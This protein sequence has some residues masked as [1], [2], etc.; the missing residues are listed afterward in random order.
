[1]A[2]LPHSSRLQATGKGANRHLLLWTPQPLASPHSTLGHPWEEGWESRTTVIITAN[3]HWT[4]LGWALSPLHA[5]IPILRAVPLWHVYYLPSRF[6]TEEAEVQTDWVTSPGSESKIRAL[7]HHAPLLEGETEKLEILVPKIR[8]KKDAGYDS[9]PGCL[10]IVW[11]TSQY[12]Q[13][14]PC[15]KSV[16]AVVCPQCSSS[17]LCF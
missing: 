1:M 4:L 7:K 3:A 14:Q 5:L 8:P 6:T 15:R 11:S 10:S 2:L 13:D 12:I 9:G 16:K 17:K